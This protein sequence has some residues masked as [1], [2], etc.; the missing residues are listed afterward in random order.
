MCDA[1]GVEVDE[2]D[3]KDSSPWPAEADGSGN[4]LVP[5]KPDRSGDPK[6]YSTWRASAKI[7]GSPG[8]DDPEV[9]SPKVLINEVLA[10]T[11]SSETDFVE[12]Y[13]PT[14]SEV[15]ISGWYLTDNSKNPQKFKIPANT[16]SLQVVTLFSGQM[17][18]ALERMG[19]TLMHMVRMFS[20][21]KP[22]LKEI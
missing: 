15:D 5:V 19:L 14:N 20:S 12:I 21:L 8:A 18:T 13:N 17:Y 3:Y 22:M 10:N 1:S 2:V 16:K 11:D 9:S 4:S 7:H 6:V